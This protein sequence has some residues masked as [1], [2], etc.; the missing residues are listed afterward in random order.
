[1]IAQIFVLLKP[2]F[3]LLCVCC[4][5]FLCIIISTCMYL[6]TWERDN[7]SSFYFLCSKCSQRSS[8]L[9]MLLERQCFWCSTSEPIAPI[10]YCCWKEIMGIWILWNRMVYLALSS[11]QF[12][13]LKFNVCRGS[14]RKRDGRTSPHLHGLLLRVLSSILFFPS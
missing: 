7:R 2:L 1:M 4:Y 12:L 11:P 5:V 14:G 8:F 13:A 3:S 6:K 9:I 10:C